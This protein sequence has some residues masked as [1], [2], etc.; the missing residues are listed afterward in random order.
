MWMWM[1][2]RTESSRRTHLKL[3]SGFHSSRFQLDFE[4]QY[5]NL[6]SI[7]NAIASLSAWA[8]FPCFPSFTPSSI[9]LHNWLFIAASPSVFMPSGL[10]LLATSSNCLRVLDSPKGWEARG[11][12]FTREIAANNQEKH[13]DG[14]LKIGKRQHLESEFEFGLEL[15]MMMVLASYFNRWPFKA[16]CLVVV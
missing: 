3:A 4:V 16:C 11:T 12:Q 10:D 9:Q 5:R 6:N 13:K 8:L 1:M 14:L 2:M 7:S 15:V